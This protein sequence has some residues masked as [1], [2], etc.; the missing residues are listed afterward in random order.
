MSENQSEQVFTEEEAHANS[1]VDAVAI[2]AVVLIIVGLA[3]YAA[4]L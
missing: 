3:T 2:L 1:R 4:S